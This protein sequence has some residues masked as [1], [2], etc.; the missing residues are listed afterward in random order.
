MV[1]MFENNKGKEIYLGDFDTK[2]EAYKKMMDFLGN[3][4]FKVY[5]TREAYYK[6][7]GYLWID[8]GSHSSFFHLYGTEE[9]CVG[10]AS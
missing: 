10:S 8:F 3:Y 2:K 5:Y 7:K 9:E 6:D 4:D 1:L